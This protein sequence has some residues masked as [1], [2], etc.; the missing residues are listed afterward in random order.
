MEIFFNR[1]NAKNYFPYFLL[2]A[3][4]FEKKN[5]YFSFR[6]FVYFA[7]KKIQHI[8]SI[9]KIFASIL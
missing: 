8:H 9:E 3:K 1:K 6:S 4:F 5:Y 7:G 2:K